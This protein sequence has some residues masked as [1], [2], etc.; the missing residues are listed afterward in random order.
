MDVLSVHLFFAI[1]I[2]TK[3][4]LSS[5]GLN[6]NVFVLSHF[7]SLPILPPGSR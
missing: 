6:F 1:L 4:I 5:S 2:A 7:S 3:I